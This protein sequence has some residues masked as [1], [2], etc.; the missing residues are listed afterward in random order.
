MRTFFGW[1]PIHRGDDHIRCEL[2][3][4]ERLV[5]LQRDKVIYSTINS[6]LVN[7]EEYLD[8]ILILV[9]KQQVAS[10]SLKRGIVISEEVGGH[11]L[12]ECF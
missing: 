9:N 1:M 8:F 12:R 5:F 11:V 3:V 4:L 10:R 6:N 2:H 7:D